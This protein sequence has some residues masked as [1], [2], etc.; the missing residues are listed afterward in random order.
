MS[1]TNIKQST[2]QFVESLAA[3]EVRP[4][5]QK[6]SK[7]VSAAQTDPGAFT[8]SSLFSIARTLHA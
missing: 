8:G 4:I 7:A 5:I 6:M 2:Q 3:E 1:W